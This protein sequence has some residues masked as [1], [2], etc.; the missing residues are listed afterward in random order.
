MC[1]AWGANE[2]AKPTPN[3]QQANSQ[4]TP[5]NQQANKETF[6]YVSNKEANTN[7]NAVVS[8]I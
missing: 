7:S 8:R 6:Y 4:P 2:Q 5:N 1:S 3:S